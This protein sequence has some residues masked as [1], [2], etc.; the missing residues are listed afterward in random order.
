MAHRATGQHPSDVEQQLKSDLVATAT[1]GNEKIALG[2]FAFETGESKA[3]SVTSKSDNR[4]TLI[5]IDE[6]YNSGSFFV[7]VQ[8]NI[9]ASVGRRY[10]SPVYF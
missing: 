8:S 9:K 1:L 5:S 7:N 6:G 2:K 4:G 10:Y 3:S